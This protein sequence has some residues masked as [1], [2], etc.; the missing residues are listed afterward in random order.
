VSFFSD[1]PT[2]KI[3]YNLPS[4]FFRH[5]QKET[6]GLRKLVLGDCRDS[7]NLQAMEKDYIYTCC[8]AEWELPQ[9]S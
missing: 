7:Q 3:G 8:F 1:S 2:R 4:D 5:T 9:R 6:D